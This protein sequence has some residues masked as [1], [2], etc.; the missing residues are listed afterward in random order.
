M[1]ILLFATQ[2]KHILNVSYI[3]KK[4]RLLINVV[5]MGLKL[6]C[7]TF[8][9]YIALIELSLYQTLVKSAASI[10]V[11]GAYKAL[12]SEACWSCVQPAN[13]LALISGPFIRPGNHR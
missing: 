4:L 11:P 9:L 13:N 5:I 6:S 8:T 2:Y 10:L 7:K 3:L 1:M 12:L